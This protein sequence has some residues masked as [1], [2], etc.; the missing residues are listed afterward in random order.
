MFKA[1][2]ELNGYRIKSVSKLSGLS[3]HVIRK[4]EHRHHLLNPYR[5]ENGYRLYFEDDLQLLLYI[6][7]QLDSGRTI[8]QL[9]KKGREQLR[10][11]MTQGAISIQGISQ[12]F[13]SQALAIVERP[14]V[15]IER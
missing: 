14:S 11:A 2:K 12:G 3:T 15:L 4:W 1:A 5:T 6:K 10:A 13:H 8:G 9:A 7:S